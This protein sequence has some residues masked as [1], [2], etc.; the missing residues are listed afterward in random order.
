[1]PVW[2]ALVR[3]THWSLGL[4]ALYARRQFRYRLPELTQ[5]VLGLAIPFLLVSHFVGA[6]LQATLFGRDVYYA[7][8]FNANWISRPYGEWVQFALLLVAWIHGCIGIY[9]WLRLKDFFARAA[10]S[11]LVAATLLPTLA[12]LGLIQGGREVVA[13]AAMP[14]WR[15]AN[16]GGEHVPAEA[17]RALLDAI[18]VVGIADSQDIPSVCQ[19]PGRY[20]LSEG[21]ARVAFDGDV[22]V[23]VDPAEIVESQMS[24]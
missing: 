1:V 20:I 12:L 16:L 4:W 5:L 13:L 6:R 9:Y 10:P 17:Q 8:V 21:D 15:A 14:E 3:I 7:Q 18:D 23:V 22:I 24:G 19:K 2:D 11:L